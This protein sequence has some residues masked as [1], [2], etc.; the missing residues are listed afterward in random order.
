M[1]ES[2]YLVLLCVEDED[3]LLGFGLTAKALD[4]EYIIF[5]E[6]DLNDEHTALAVL[7]SPQMK[8][9]LATLPLFLKGGESKHGL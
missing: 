8:R 2:N 9:H 7:P 4:S 3:E 6:P 5:T 1:T